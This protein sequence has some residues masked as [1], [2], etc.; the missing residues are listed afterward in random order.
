MKKVE[1]IRTC[2]QECDDNEIV[3][4]VQNGQKEYFDCLIDRYEQK[5]FFYIMR[6]V[7]NAEE[8][9]D[10]VQNVFVKA[11][12]HIDT[13]DTNKKFSSWIYRIAHNETMNWFSKKKQRKTVSIENLGTTKDFLNA[14]DDSDTALEKTTKGE[15][16]DNMS[17]ALAQLPKQY[18]KVLYMKYFEDRSYKEMGEELNK[19]TSTIGTLLRR[20]KKR[21][22]T[23]IKKTDRI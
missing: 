18:A 5:L 14:A 9:H 23:I 10:I 16:R 21:L 19:P 12:D 3:V 22:Q 20:A 7:K 15:L 6:Y 11:L 13:F 4:H 1:N 17:D 2:S 8:S